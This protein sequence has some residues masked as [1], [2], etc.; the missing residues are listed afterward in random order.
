MY[1]NNGK[2]VVDV[3]PGISG[4]ISTAFFCF[5]KKPLKTSVFRGNLKNLKSGN[6]A[7]YAGLLFL[8]MRPFCFLEQE[9]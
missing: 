4:V 3:I 2:E 1:R 7:V 6:G 9:R 5:M 8:Y